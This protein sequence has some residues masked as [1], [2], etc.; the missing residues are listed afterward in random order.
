MQA[1]RGRARY[2][3]ERSVGY[4]DA[5]ATTMYYFIRTVAQAERNA[6]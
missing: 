4:V 5:G 1:K 2:L 6:E 3:R